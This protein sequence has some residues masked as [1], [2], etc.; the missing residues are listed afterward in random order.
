MLKAARF[1][2]SMGFSVIACGDTKRALLPWK[3]YQSRIINDEELKIQFNHP[4]CAGLAVVCGAVSGG[5]EVI[6]VDLKYD[7]TGTLWERFK[8]T[9]EKIPGLYIV[10]T[11]SGGYHIYYRCEVIEGNQKLANRPATTEELKENPHIKEIV[12]IET[13]GEAG[14]VIAPPTQGYEKITDF[15][16]PVLSI[17]QREYILSAARSFN[18]VFEEEKIPPRVTQS[19]V[20]YQKT[21][22]D[23]YNEKCD[24][25]ALLEKHGWSFMEKRGP[26]SLLKRPG[27]SDQHSGD[28]HHE[29]NLFKVFSTSTQFELKK[30]YS[31]FA[32][33]TLLEHN[34]DFSAAAKQLIADGYG[35]AGAMG[36]YGNKVLKSLGMGIP[37][38]QISQRLISENGFTQKDADRI[39]NDIE[40]IN[41]PEILTFWEVIHT[42]SKKTINILRYKLVSFLYDNGFHLFFYDV[43]NNSYRIVQQKDGFV[44]DASFET[45]K[46]FVKEYILSLP[47]KFD[48]ITPDEL[49]DVVMKGTDTFFGKGLIEF[50][51]AKELDI[52][53][54][55]PDAAFFTFSNGIVKVTRNGAEL[56]SYGEVA[57]PVWRSQVIDF[58]IDVDNFFDE[59]LCEFYSF[60]GH[61]AADRLDY[62]LSLIGY[63][64]H[65]YKDPARPHAI[66]LAEETE[67]ETKG[68]GTG[69]GILVKA[70]SYMAN[71]ARVDGKNFKLDKNFAF[72]RV[73]LD[74]KIVAIE[75]VR[76]NVDFEGFYAIITEGMTIERKNKD[77]FFIPY[78]DSPKILFTTNYTIAGNGGHGKR[79][80]KLFEF[81]NYFSATYT[82]VDEYK[83][84]LFDDWD[85]DEW[86]RFYNLMF[87]CVASYLQSGIKPMES[88][89]KT[90]RKHMRLNFS[91][92]FMDWW[93]GYVENGAG[94]FKAF[95]DI[96]AAYLVSNN[97]ERKDYSQKR[98]RAAINEAADRFGYQIETRRVGIE[99]LHQLRIYS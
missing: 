14:Y 98:F 91:P 3:E 77:E 33:Y 17:D 79:R 37:K 1:Y 68:G 22:W 38:Q 10:R 93:D 64:L 75:D 65:R 13:R 62:L 42:R 24:V 66:I 53:K 48:S 55:T 30:G 83:H 31:P 72:Q 11:R 32:V 94:E 54:D 50:I 41:G 88:S 7:T 99:K 86:N 51:D 21:P 97:M 12:L 70:I 87:T 71:V 43:H 96:Y 59:S 90:H 56:L 15:S 57:K 52:L 58:K 67:D 5:L 27:T 63:L 23:D 25:I 18:E 95:R 8:Q 35:E 29:L 2:T 39:I 4:K 76:K 28:Y 84:N 19:A 47:E 80:Q 9:I 82:P 60:L 44:Q 26:R 78:A 34:N 85:P 6:D 16:V 89:I 40:E 45:I 49:M 20:S 61:V 69:K 73:G 74:T 92:E 81:T 36:K 46:K